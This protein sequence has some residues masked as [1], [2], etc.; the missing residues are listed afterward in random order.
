MNNQEKWDYIKIGSLNVDGLVTRVEKQQKICN[1]MLENEM[2]ILCIQEWS[3][4]YQDYEKVFAKTEFE[5]Y[6]EV[7]N[8]NTHTAIIVNQNYR[9]MHH[10]Q[11][12]ELKNGRLLWRTWITI[13]GIGKA[14]NIC[15][16]YWSPSDSNGMDAMDIL[17]NDIN[18]IESINSEYENYYCINDDF[19]ARSE[20]WD[21][22]CEKA[23]KRGEYLEEWLY[24]EEYFIQN[25]G[26]VTHFNRATKQESAIDLTITCDKLGAL[27][28]QWYVD[29]NSR[30]TSF[31][32]SDHYF[33]VMCIDF[34]PIEISDKPYIMFDYR[35]QDYESYCVILKQLLIDWYEYFYDNWK[36]QSKLNDITE[37]LQDII[38]Y[39]ALRVFGIKKVK[40]RDKFWLGKRARVA[41]EQ[42]KDLRKEYNK[43]RNDA[44]AKKIKTKI[45]KCTSIINKC[46]VDAIE[47][48]RANME[49]T[50]NRL[51]RDDSKYFWHLAK[52]ATNDNKSSICPLKDK[53]GKIIAATPKKQAE[54]L[55]KH[56][57][58]EIG[59]NE[60]CYNEK[61]R[62]WHA[63]VTETVTKEWIGKETKEGKERCKKLNEPISKQ[64]ILHAIEK[65]K[66]DTACGHDSISM[67]MIHIGRFILAP[68]LELLF[69][70]IFL[71]YGIFP[72][73]WLL[74]NIYLFSLL[75]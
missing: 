25:N 20:L 12:K 75:F 14:L 65:S 66:L 22:K 59:E 60:K 29:Q 8:S 47:K 6:F 48:Y 74:I 4:N 24:D 56:F 15:S 27:V 43:C 54:I 63:K 71:V 35:E 11:F 13:Y 57:N 31:N 16:I 9:V 7:Y 40:K 69:N 51:N 52:K 26:F 3:Q 55:H 23:D 44:K 64:Q 32:I 39:G 72:M 2:D 46:K 34:K 18:E 37:Y 1:W 17:N 73:C 67:R 19:N 49:S 33:L 68:A 41:I 30:S 10:K 36:N 62:E 58:R 50:I 61:H 42:R 70:L 45:N 53:N 5:K 21:D 38:K 28:K